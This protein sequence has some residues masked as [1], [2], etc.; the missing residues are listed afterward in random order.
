M[1]QTITAQIGTQH[2]QTTLTNSRHTLTADENA[3]HAGED[4]GPNPGELLMMSLASC[5]AITLRMY[6]DRKQ[7]DI[8]S[9]KV[10]VTMEKKED[11]TQFNRTIEVDGHID[12]EAKNRLITIAKACP[13]HKTLTHPIEINTTLL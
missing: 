2:Y 12:Q 10:H 9:I 7:W 3:E 1:T 8:S 5:T 13:V 11:S 4:L 6:A